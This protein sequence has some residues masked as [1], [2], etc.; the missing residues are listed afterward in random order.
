MLLRITNQARSYAWG[1]K[2]LLPALQGVPADGTPKAEIW[3]GTHPA[4]PSDI[5]AALVSVRGNTLDRLVSKPLKFL[6]K[7]LAAGQPLSI[8]AHPSRER[9][10]QMFERENELGL[11]IDDPKR[12]YRDPNHKPEILIAVTEFEALSGFRSV[13]SILVEFEPHHSFTAHEF[14]EALR[15]GGH[16]AAMAQAFALEPQQVDE[17]V[18]V[19]I[20]EG[21][22][23]GELLM[24]LGLLHPA[25]P[26]LLVSVL[27]N[28]VYLQPEQAIYLPAGNVHAYISGLG[29][30]VMAASDNVLRGG[31]TKK[32]IDVPELLAVADFSVL[33][34]PRVPVREQQSG[35]TEY[36]TPDRDFSVYRVEPNRQTVLLDFPVRSDSIMV[37]VSGDLTLSTN[38][39]DL[40]RLQP[41]EGAFIGAEARLLSVQ[42]SGVGYLA[43]DAVPPI[44]LT[45]GDS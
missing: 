28:H 18:N 29:V 14:F 25:D 11:A 43:R 1:S 9:A 35:V 40:Q 19:M 45:S 16:E 8:Q 39:G 20:R 26:G 23:R 44:A 4:D 42:G 30:E 3:F 17:L 13:E 6:V 38:R 24:R 27:L 2:T 32:H 37:C 5:D 21:H 12:N 7:L 34:E 31:L 10:Q 15:S 22:A 41:G 36:L 33:E